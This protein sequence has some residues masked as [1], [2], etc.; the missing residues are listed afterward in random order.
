ME[1]IKCGTALDDA[2]RPGRPARYCSKAC[3]RAAEFEVRRLTAAIEALEQDA[4]RVRIGAHGTPAARH[5][6]L[7]RITAETTAA[8]E[9]L[10]ALLAASEGEEVP[11]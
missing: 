8:E 11:A 2:P 4:R 6:R 1:C 10:R 5:E 7:G 3:R 9:R